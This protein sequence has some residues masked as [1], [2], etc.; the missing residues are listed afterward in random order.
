MS[1]KSN[2]L[3]A[4]IFSALGSIAVADSSIK[5]DDAYA[6]SSNKHA[7]AGAAFMMIINTGEEDDRLIGAIS[8]A[9]DRVELHTHKVDENG[10]AKMFH[11][12]EG[13][14]IPAGE[15]YVLRRGGDHVMF[16]GLT[17]PFE[18]DATVPVT[19]VFEQAGEVEIEVP[20]D[21]NRKGNGANSH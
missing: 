19:L 5:V 16:M 15:T 14:V 6:R 9:A 10:V 21:L 7:K 1:L 20:V 4:M 3:T 17:K 11:V 13:F 2:L 18:Q 8:D 12:K